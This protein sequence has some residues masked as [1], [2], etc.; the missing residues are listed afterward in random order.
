MPYMTY[1]ILFFYPC[2][3][4]FT[5]M[6][7]VLPIIIFHQGSIGWCVLYQCVRQSVLRW[8]NAGQQWKGGNTKWTHKNRAPTRTVQSNCTLTLWLSTTITHEQ[9]HSNFTQLKTKLDAKIFKRFHHCVCHQCCLL[10]FHSWPTYFWPPISAL[11]YLHIFP[12]LYFTI[13]S[14]FRKLRRD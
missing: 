11:T 9:S 7:L 5:I 14:N 13:L 4:T 12:S 1:N 3:N 8:G 6:L 10:K 2:F